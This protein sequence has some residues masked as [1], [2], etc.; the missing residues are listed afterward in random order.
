MG[1]RLR[2][3]AGGLAGAP[4]GTTREESR[5]RGRRREALLGLVRLREDQL[6]DALEQLAEHDATDASAPEAG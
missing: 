6:A 1:P 5:R 4:E 3:I 2:A